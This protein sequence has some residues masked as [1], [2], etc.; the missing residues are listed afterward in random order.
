[1]T[2]IEVVMTRNPG[3]SLERLQ[4]ATSK[5]KIELCE[6]KMLLEIFSAFAGCLSLV[7]P[8]LRQSTSA[9]S[10]TP[11]WNKPPLES[12]GRKMTKSGKKTDT[13]RPVVA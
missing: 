1:M 8:S 11:L 2:E 7:R 4:T 9:A 12:I 5:Q 10:S 13:S 3:L 6:F